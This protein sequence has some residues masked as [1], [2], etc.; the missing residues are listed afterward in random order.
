MNKQLIK[1][2]TH[3]IQLQST[4]KSVSIIRVMALYILRIKY[5][6]GKKRLTE[7]DNYFK[8]QFSMIG[9]YLT[10]ADME[11]LLKDEADFEMT[12]VDG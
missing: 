9:D 8:E 3:K 5:G 12:E 4:I 10:L 6:W 7:F 1:K 11:N 2:A